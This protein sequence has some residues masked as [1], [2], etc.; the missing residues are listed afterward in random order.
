MF[1]SGDDSFKG[2]RDLAGRLEAEPG[3]E[4]FVSYLRHRENGLRKQAF[5]SLSQFISTAI[6]WDFDRRRDF[7]DRLCL[8]QHELP[9]VSN[10]V[11]HP[12]HHDLVLPTLREWATREPNNPI[13]F[14][15]QGSDEDLRRAVALDS[16]EWIAREMLAWRLLAGVDYSIH[17]LPNGYG[18]IGDPAEDLRLLDEVATLANQLPPHQAGAI[19]EEAAETREVVLAYLEYQ[20]A[21]SDKN[22]RDWM[23]NQNRPLLHRW[24][25]VGYE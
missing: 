24:L 5:R 17:E 23:W 4:L 9:D 20:A 16:N 21:A 10:L 15:W 1:Y 25:R 8:L 14:R 18:Y 7:A 22:F 12:L 3:L 13:P 6:A 2:L 11:P 19:A